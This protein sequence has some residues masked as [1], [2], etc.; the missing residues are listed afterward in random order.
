MPYT[1]SLSAAQKAF[2]IR[3]DPVHTVIKRC[4]L[5]PR[6]LSTWRESLRRRWQKEKKNQFAVYFDLLSRTH[7]NPL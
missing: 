7:G 4:N 6:V 1:D 2:T 5:V 3:S